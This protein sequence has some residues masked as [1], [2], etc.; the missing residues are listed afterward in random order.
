MFENIA[1]SKADPLLQLIAD[2]A[3]DDRP[4]KLDLGVGVFKDESGSTPVLD[5]VKQAE[6]RLLRD[7]G[8]KSYVGMLGDVTFGRAV[9]ELLLGPEL[10]SDRLTSL[11]TPGG[12]GALRLLFET[13]KLARP[14][15]TVW[16]S[17]PG[18]ANHPA[19]VDGTGLESRTYPYYDPASSTLDFSA[20]SD[21]LRGLGENDVVL[22]HGCCH[23]PTGASLSPAQW[24][25]V[26]E[27]A[28]ERGFLPF[29]DLAYQG[30]GAGLEADAY[31]VRSLAAS[32]PELLIAYSCSKNF[33]IYRDRT[34]AALTLSADADNA[35]RILAQMTRI[36]RADYSMPPDHGAAVV[37]TILHD[38]TLKAQWM[39][40]LDTMQQR[41]AGVRDRLTAAFRDRIGSD[42]FDFVAGQE[43]MFSL[44]GLSREQVI[45]LREEHAVYMAG[46]SR[47]NIAGLREAQ[48]PA[49]VEAV[50]A[51]L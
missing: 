10:L 49:F 47:I 48:I 20:M 28:L 40:E 7:Q 16:L 26:V 23:N 15:A 45:R 1:A 38:E 27:I 24:D 39:Q 43:G 11:Q 42:R 35:G 17:A 25:E 12:C 36:A 8:S 22:L 14:G 29:V 5:S 32:V 13:V 21:C 30:F 6:Q 19:I 51:V 37:S 46:D 41:L 44:L 3:A 18:W 34:G 4:D 2:F 31:G 50:A 33:A 9:S